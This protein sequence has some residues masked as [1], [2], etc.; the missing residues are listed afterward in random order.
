MFNY[1]LFKVHLN[2]E[3][4]LKNLTSVFASGFINEGQQ[5]IELERRLS[6]YLEVSNLTLMNSCTSALTT[7]LR[8]IGV[9]KGD[10]VIS[11]AMT[12]VATNTPIVNAGA[13]LIWADIDAD[14]GMISAED[15][16][17]LITPRTKA[18][19][20]VDWAGT[21]ADLRSFQIIS[22][23]Y[24]LPVIQD[25]AHAF[26]A[27]LEGR[28]ISEF[29]DFTCFS[30]QAIKHFT[31]GD[32]GAL[33]CRRPE[34]HLLAK[35]LKWFGYD[36]DAVKD[37]K[38]EWKGQKWD[39]D[40]L[41]EEVGYKFNLNNMSAAVGLA[42][43]PNM[44]SVLAKH[45]A[46]AE[47]YNSLLGSHPLVHLLYTPVDALSSFWVYTLRL[48]LT[49]TQRDHVMAT[50]NAKGIGAGLVHLPNS[51]YSAFREFHRELPNTELFSST[52]ISLPCG[53]WLKPEDIRTIA[54]NLLI[55]LDAKDA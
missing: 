9:G 49:E 1:P 27:R 55:E 43:L 47:L 7:A 31:T 32:G 6:E 44:D 48:K 46:N 28:P 2:Q 8:I 21:P 4:A 54:E 50:L 12:C 52:Q 42:N 40:I 3:E 11:T 38:G 34:D 41:A 14:S 37:A 16:E 20:I 23:K 45:R 15:V 35:K 30:F 39:A 24:S 10:E 29:T 19:M 17:K 25:A 26:G 36:R 18:I 22:E 33:I 5:V 53:W 51:R 13:K